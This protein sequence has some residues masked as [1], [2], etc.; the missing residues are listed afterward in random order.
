MVELLVGSEM[1]KQ[2]ATA[3]KQKVRIPRGRILFFE[4]IKLWWWEGESGGLTLVKRN[5]YSMLVGSC[6]H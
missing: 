3:T 6:L 4:K 2:L 5:I 1:G